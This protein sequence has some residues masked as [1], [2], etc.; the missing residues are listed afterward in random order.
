M[1]GSKG[2]QAEHQYDAVVVLGAGVSEMCIRRL[3]LG[4]ELLEKGLAKVLIFV[5][6]SEEEG[7]LAR[8]MAESHGIELSIVYTDTNSKNTVDNA[9]YAKAILKKLKARR[10]ALVTSK[11]HMQRALAIFDWVLGDGYQLEPFPVEDIP[12]GSL[13][14]REEILKMFIPIMK[15]LFAKGDDEGI[16]KAADLLDPIIGTLV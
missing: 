15:A 16:K 8:A 12:D 4:L 3:E 5:G 14:Y 7:R 9:Y 10:V 6:G 11:F 13:V 2:M 1:A